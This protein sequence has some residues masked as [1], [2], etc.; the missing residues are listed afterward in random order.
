MNPNF[1]CNNGTNSFMCSAEVACSE[2]YRAN[3]T[4][5]TSGI[6][7]SL[8]IEK[9]LYCEKSSIWENS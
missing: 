5:E 8:V 6:T 4:V 1:I 7:R 3:F 9:K 2:P